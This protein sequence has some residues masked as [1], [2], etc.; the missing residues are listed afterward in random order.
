M[1]P[2]SG[3][4]N[5]PTSLTSREYSESRLTVE[6]TGELMLV[7]CLQT[8]FSSCLQDLTGL[9]H[10]HRYATAQIIV[11]IFATPLQAALQVFTTHLDLLPRAIGLKSSAFSEVSSATLFLF[12][13]FLLLWALAALLLSLLGSW[14]FPDTLLSCS[15]L[16]L[17]SVCARTSCDKR[18]ALL[19][20]SA[21]GWNGQDGE[22]HLPDT[23]GLSD[24][25]LLW[26]SIAAP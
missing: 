15:P 10:R 4:S 25:R 2:A 18:V 21:K 23:T 12:F 14:P 3:A 8:S 26:P 24:S 19:R 17:S 1:L 6:V 13:A 20:R 16:L 22:V 9:Q 11:M 7:N 5:S